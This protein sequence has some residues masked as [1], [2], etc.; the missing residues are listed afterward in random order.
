MRPK[1]R[2]GLARIQEAWVVVAGEKTAARSKITSL[3]GGVLRI[4]LHS[5]ALKHHLA[6]FRSAELIE[7]LNRRFPEAG[8]RTLKFVIGKSTQR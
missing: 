2:R 4:E 8:V 7:E 6:T 3:E 5:A 1:N